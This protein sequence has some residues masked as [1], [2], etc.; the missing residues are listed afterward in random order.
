MTRVPITPP[1]DPHDSSTW[2]APVSTKNTIHAMTK[3]HVYT[4]EYT[5][6]STPNALIMAM[7]Q[8]PAEV[9]RDLPAFPR[10]FD[11]KANP[12][13]DGRNKGGFAIQV[14]WPGVD[15]FADLEDA[16]D[17]LDA[18]VRG[19]MDEYDDCDGA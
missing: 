4:A 6:P 9:P 15:L 19:G 5:I 7:L 17:R 3:A 18:D 2:V 13:R 1:I 12:R 11:V 8:L 14:T 16:L 10:F